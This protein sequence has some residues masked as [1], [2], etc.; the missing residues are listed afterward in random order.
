VNAWGGKD[1][2]PLLEG[3]AKE[4]ITRKQGERNSLDAIFPLVGGRIEGQ[5]GFKPFP[6]QGMI[7]A[8]L[9][10][11]ASVKSVPEVASVQVCHRRLLLI[12]A[13]TASLPEANNP[14]LMIPTPVRSL[15]VPHEVLS[16]LSSRPSMQLTMANSLHPKSVSP[17]WTT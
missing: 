16:V 8:L 4:Y 15:Q 1:G 12:K 5:E 14:I 10:L 2:E 6:G 17:G 7:N 3:A 9:V 11:M 13:Q